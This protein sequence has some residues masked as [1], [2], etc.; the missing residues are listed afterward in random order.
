S[1][2]RYR[3]GTSRLSVGWSASEI[4][5]AL[6]SW[7]RRL[8]LLPSSLWRFHPLRR[9]SPPLAVAFTRLAA[10]RFVF[11]FGMVSLSSSS[12]SPLR[13]EGRVRGVGA[14]FLL[15]SLSLRERAGVRAGAPSFSSPSPSGRGP[16]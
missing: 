8:G 5:A 12:P 3:Y 16:G 15:I 1:P 14:P 7:R 6:R 9:L 4:N 10:A 13:V 11:I 2:L